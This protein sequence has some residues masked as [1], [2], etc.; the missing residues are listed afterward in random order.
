MT[1]FFLSNTIFTFSFKKCNTFLTI[2]FRVLICK[3]FFIYIFILIK[4]ICLLLWHHLRE[5]SCCNCLVIVVEKD[6]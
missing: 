2:L 4:H 5:L 3:I 1:S 6:H